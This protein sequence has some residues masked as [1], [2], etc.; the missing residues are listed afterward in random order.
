MKSGNMKT[1]SDFNH[2]AVYGLIAV[3]GGLAVSILFLMSDGKPAGARAAEV[4]PQAAAVTIETAPVTEIVQTIKPVESAA[5]EVP[6]LVEGDSAPVPLGESKKV[7][8]AVEA[9]VKAAVED[10]PATAKAAPAKSNDAWPM[11][12]VGA[13]RTDSDSIS[14]ERAVL[15]TDGLDDGKLGLIMNKSAVL[16]TRAPY[17]RVSIGAPEVADVNAIGPNNI[18]VTAKKPGTTQLIVWDDS[19]RSQVVDV[20]VSIDLAALQEQF[21]QQFPGSKINVSMANGQVVLRGQAPSLLV[22]EQA[23]Q[24]AAPFAPKVL[25][26]IEISGGQQV[27]LQVRFAEVSRSATNQLGFNFGT[28]DGKSVFGSNIGTGPLGLGAGTGNAGSSLV[29]PSPSPTV[30]LFGTGGI[31]NTQFA[32][33]IQALRQNNLLRVL[34]EPNLTAMSGQEASFLAGGSFPVPVTQGGGAGSG[35]PAIT[36]EYRSF[37]VKLNFTPVVLGDGKIRLKVAPEV[38]DLDFTTA[39]QFG[40]FVI[41]GLTERKLQ[42]TV[43]LR[44]GQTFALAGLLNNNVS[45]TKDVTPVLGDLPVVGALFRSVRYQRKETELV[46]IVTPRLVEAMN[47]AQVPQLPGE[48]WRHPTEGDLFWQRDIGG[49]TGDLKKAAAP[50]RAGVTAS[51]EA[52]RFKGAFGYVPVKEEEE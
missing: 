50:G 6:P 35:A 20:A 44:E 13:V 41:P 14:I 23:A 16:S 8:A 36:V 15:I 25:N 29:A 21:K 22:A 1:K 38:S 27:M 46:V 28:T 12:P 18:L 19:D 9:G 48:K 45:A 33:Y 4:K 47:P 49:P 17:K 51:G 5:V 31:G 30:T 42:T 24:L 39:V 11:V 26:F 7:A 3:A 34:A 43:E 52:P 32:Y 2:R 37:G 10:K 40:G